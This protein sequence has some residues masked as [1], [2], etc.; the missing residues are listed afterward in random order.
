M[1]LWK[2]V[3]EKVEKNTFPI[4]RSM[5]WKLRKEPA[6]T[7][8][9]WSFVPTRKYHVRWARQWRN[10]RMLRTLPFSSTVHHLQWNQT[11][12]LLHNEILNITVTDRQ[13]DGQ[14]QTHRRTDVHQDTQT[15]ARKDRN[16]ARRR[17]QTQTQEA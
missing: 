12:V 4:H 13:K 9:D 10:D 5:I 14:R 2:N 1:T 11:L 16:E 8:F 6:T 17:R 3:R 15:D 7:W